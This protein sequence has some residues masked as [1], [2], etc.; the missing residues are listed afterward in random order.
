MENT[1]DPGYKHQ[2]HRD[3]LSQLDFMEGEIRFFGQEL[4]A[5]SEAHPNLPSIWGQ[6]EE[7]QKL[8]EAKQAKIAAL[9]AEIHQ[10][11]QALAANPAHTRLADVQHHAQVRERIESLIVNFEQLKVNFRR[12]ASR[13]D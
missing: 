13:N 12:F 1:L 8:F 5:V 9:R 4:T 10:H 7:Y 6:V 2:E 11:E 3:W